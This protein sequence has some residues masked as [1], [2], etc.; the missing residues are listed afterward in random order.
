MSATRILVVDDEFS[1]RNLLQRYLQ[2][3][4]YS[5]EVAENGA[6]ALQ[7]LKTFQPQLVI[8]DLNLPDISGYEVCQQMRQET[9]VLILMLTSRVSPSDK[10]MGF[11]LG[12]DDYLTKPFNLPE[13]E[14]RVAAL[15]RRQRGT[16]TPTLPP[17]LHSGL[18]ID[19]ESRS[20]K[21]EE[22]LIPLTA[23]EFDLLYA[24]A[25]CPGKVLRRSQ[26]IQEVWDFNHGGD[27]RVVDVHIGQI[28]KKLEKD[29]S[30]PQFILT[31][32]GVG[33][34]FAP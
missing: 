34:K 32:R 30:Q 26:L 28:R 8:L 23:L 5:V 33:Y 22:D 16:Q 13:L 15:L 12:A 4:N 11:S 18:M 17:L 10:L 9:G 20:V 24:L 21:R 19:L 1:I 25:R 2:R 6:E 3:R 27:E 14:A 31:V 29:P 7:L